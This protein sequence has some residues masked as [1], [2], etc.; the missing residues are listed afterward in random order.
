MDASV[1]NGAMVKTGQSSQAE[2]KARVAGS[3][4]RDAG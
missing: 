1:L 2:R 3:V 4:L